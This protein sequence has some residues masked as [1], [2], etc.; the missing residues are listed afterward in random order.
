MNISVPHDPAWFVNSLA[1][2]HCIH[3]KTNFKYIVYFAHDHPPTHS[4]PCQPP[5][6]LSGKHPEL[7]ELDHIACLWFPQRP[8]ELNSHQQ[9]IGDSIS[10][11]PHQHL[12]LLVLMRVIITW[13]RWDNTCPPLHLSY[14]VCD[15]HTWRSHPYSPFLSRHI[16]LNTEPQK[17]M[18]LTFHL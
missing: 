6:I 17:G 13:V 2:I 12:L 5:T 10:Q 15:K 9:W 1:Y 16:W 14:L 8:H 3:C 11:H 4:P 7:V 18:L